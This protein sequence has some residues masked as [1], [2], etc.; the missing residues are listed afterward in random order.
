MS[1]LSDLVRKAMA[2]S[3]IQ[4]MKEWAESFDRASS[5]L[6]ANM[7]PVIMYGTGDPPSPDGLP[8]GT[9]YLQYTP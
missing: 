1:A 8:E 7:V 6:E 9:L 2:N 3:D 4:R 5:E